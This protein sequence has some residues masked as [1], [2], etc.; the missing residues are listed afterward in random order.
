MLIV[1]YFYFCY[2]KVKGCILE[3]NQRCGFRIGPT[4][5]SLAFWIYK[6]EKL[7]Y[8]CSEHK[9]ADQVTAKLIC[10]FVLRMQDVGLSWLIFSSIFI[11]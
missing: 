10:A 9:G 5:R 2:H 1:L 7:Y 4:A 6:E 3:K 11:S 8:L